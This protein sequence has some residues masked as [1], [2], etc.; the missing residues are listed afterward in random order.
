M[1]H[2]PRNNLSTLD[3][4]TLKWSRDQGD[5]VRLIDT[6]NDFC[7]VAVLTELVTQQTGFGLSKMAC[8]V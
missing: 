7:N 2:K 6:N 8:E 3:Q 5:R 4:K 1:N